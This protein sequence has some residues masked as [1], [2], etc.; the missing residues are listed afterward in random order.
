MQKAEKEREGEVG[1][2]RTGKRNPEK[3]GKGAGK[4]RKIIA[5]FL[6]NN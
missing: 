6:A 4:E 5:L 3:R 2:G 1:G